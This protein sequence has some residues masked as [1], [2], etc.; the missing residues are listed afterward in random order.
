MAKARG[1]GYR[2]L[3]GSFKHASIGKP[4]VALTARNPVICEFQY[5]QDLTP[6]AS[7]FAATMP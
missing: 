7:K 4:P 3:H 6:R 2:P 1:L 5:K